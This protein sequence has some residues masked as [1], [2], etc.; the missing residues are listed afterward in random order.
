MKKTLNKLLKRN[1]I[2]NFKQFLSIVVIVFLSMTLLSGFITNA[3]TLECSVE[4][5]FEETNLADA[6]LYVDGVTSQDEEFFVKNQIDYEKRLEFGVLANIKNTTAQNNAKIFVYDTGKISTPYIVSGGSGCYIDQNVAKSKGLKTA[7]DVICFDYDYDINIGSE[8]YNLKL[9][10]EFLITGTMSLCECADTYS[11]WPVLIEKQVFLNALNHEISMQLQGAMTGITPQNISDLQYNQVLIKSE[12]IDEDLIKIKGFYENNSSSNLML[13]LNRDMID[14]VV[15]LS[16]EVSQ[17][18]KMIYIFPMIFLLVSML[19]IITSVSQLII[20]EKMNIGTLKAMGVDKK[21]LLNHYSSYGA[22]L[23]GIGSILGII[24]GP[25]VIPEV[26]FVKYDLVYSI[27]KDY[28]SLLVPYLPLLI[29]FIMFILIGYFVSL[30]T[31]LEI[32]NKKP[33]YCLKSEIKIKLK[34]KKKRNKLPVSLKM[35]FRNIITKPV[36]TVMAIIGIAGC[37]ALM[38]CGFGIGDTLQN[39]LD[40]DLKRVFK[41][42][43]STTYS[44]P[45]FIFELEEIEGI[46]YFETYERHYA[47]ISK[48]NAT[49]NDN[50]YRIK[51]D[52]KYVSFSLKYGEAVISKSIAEKIGAN[53]GDSISVRVGEKSVDIKI[54]NFIET[55]LMD[56]IYYCEDYFFSETYASHG[57]WISCTGNKEEIVKKINGIN[58][59]NDAMSMNEIRNFAENKISS[60]SIM[61]TTLKVFAFALAIVVLFN[62]IFL[63]LRERVKQIATLKV[64]GQNLLLVNLSVCFELLF[65]GLIGLIFGIMLGYPLLILV[66]TVNKVEIINFLF[67]ISP[68]S[69]VLS[70]IIILSTVLIIS[71]FSI[72]KIKKV[73]M[74][75]ALKSNE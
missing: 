26:M 43:I 25:L 18:K 4:R 65:I 22:V 32:I 7:Q 71:L 57:M 45:N 41:Y 33:V 14:S 21:S 51:E 74:T 63:I 23:C 16:S 62:F 19:I 56:G 10:F 28:V 35:A 17:S 44:K 6:W 2:S 30:F 60:I 42:D 31:C 55:S 47:E 75:Q 61:T 5:Y 54:T 34:S 53:V 24:V 12:K 1:I 3:N 59:T 52:S 11:S 67:Y 37:V 36:R 39:S 46:D 58:G 49:A 38:L 72:I 40:N 13:T 29:M 8:I 68:I 15:L 27:P 20:Q 48:G 9:N 69:F 66:L 73:S 64:I 50:I 70:A